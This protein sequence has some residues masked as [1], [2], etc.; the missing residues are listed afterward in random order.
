MV[1]IENPD[2]LL[3]FLEIGRMRKSHS[4]TSH[5]LTGK[6]KDSTEIIVIDCRPATEFASQHVKARQV[7]N[8]GS[9]ILND[10]DALALRLTEIKLQVLDGG[11]NLFQKIV[12]FFL[13]LL[14]LRSRKVWEFFN[15]LAGQFFFAHANQKHRFLSL[16]FYPGPILSAKRAPKPNL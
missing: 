12:D 16:V 10:P 5:R 8:L 2:W 6:L 1:S 9:E 13:R 15:L 11:R 14:S 3:T 4:P 7:F